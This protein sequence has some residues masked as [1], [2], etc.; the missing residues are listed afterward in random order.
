MSAFRKL[1]TYC[2]ASRWVL[3]GHQ[4]GRI[5]RRDARWRAAGDGLVAAPDACRL[6][7]R[8][9]QARIDAAT[10]DVGD[11]RLDLLLARALVLLEQDRGRHHDAGN[12]EPA[13]R[14]VVG[15]ES[16]LHR[17]AALARQALDRRDV[18][19]LD[20]ADIGLAGA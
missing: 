16:E 15:D 14:D 2:S 20:R 3:R 8:L 7:D 17:M 19:A 12:A 13:L 5:R 9:D 1:C 11:R 4:P 10:A 6:H 18:A